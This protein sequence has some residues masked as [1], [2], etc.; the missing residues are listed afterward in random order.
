MSA[1]IAEVAIPAAKT[2]DKATLFIKLPLLLSLLVFGVVY[3]M[4]DYEA[5]SPQRPL[6]SLKLHE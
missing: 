6:R 5:N 2:N 3:S 4:T 1:A